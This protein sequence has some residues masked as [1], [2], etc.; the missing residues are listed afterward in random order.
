M[1]LYVAAGFDLADAYYVLDVVETGGNTFTVTMSSGTHFLDRTGAAASGDHADLAMGYTSFLTALQTALNAGTD[2]GTGYTVSFSATTARVTITRS[3][4]AGVSAVQLTATTR[5]T[6]I[7]QTSTKSGSLSYEMDVTPYHWISGTIGYWSNWLE[8]EDR[9]GVAYDVIAHS[10]RPHGIARSVVPI[11][12]DF[13]VPLEPRAVVYSTHAAAATPW[14]W[15]HLFKHARNTL[16]LQVN[17]GTHVHYLRLR[18]DGAAFVPRAR[19][20]DYVG[21]WDVPI[22]ARLL[23]RETL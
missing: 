17:D 15:Q 21:H 2:G 9:D 19:A 1:A 23:A 6:Y 18:E 13:I 3:T 8:R 7:G 5:G 16:P 14:T 4:A 11:E 22:R 20:A 10:G 12:V